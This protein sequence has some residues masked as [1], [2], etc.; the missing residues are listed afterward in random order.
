[1]LF[2]LTYFYLQNQKSV[3][4]TSSVNV[5]SAKQIKLGKV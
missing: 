3:M 2:E 4:R 5:S 1:M